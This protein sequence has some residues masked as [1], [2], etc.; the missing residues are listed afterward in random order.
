MIQLDSGRTD[1]ELQAMSPGLCFDY[2]P[3]LSPLV[4]SLYGFILKVSLPVAGYLVII[5]RKIAQLEVEGSSDWLD[6][7]M[8]PIQGPEGR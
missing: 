3:F 7:I 6:L 2:S 1:S 5:Q 4:S 8:C